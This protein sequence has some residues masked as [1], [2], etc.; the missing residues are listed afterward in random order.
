MIFSLVI[1]Q[2]EEILTH[3]FSTYNDFILSVDRIE[4]TRDHFYD[5]DECS[6]LF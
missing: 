2:V 5:Q 1:N 6:R 3:D 4:N